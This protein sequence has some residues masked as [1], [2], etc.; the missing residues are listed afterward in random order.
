MI[1][2]SEIR[3][4]DAQVPPTARSALINAN[5]KAF[6]VLSSNLYKDKPL[7]ILRELSANALDAHI[8]AGNT[9]TPFVVSLP[10]SLRPSL[11]IRDY[12]TG[13]DDQAILELYMTYFGSNKGSSNIFTGGLG[14][15]SKTPFAYTDA[16]SVVSRYNG[17]KRTYS[18]Y[19][20]AD[21]T[22]KIVLLQEEHTDE[23]N[24]LEVSVPVR[25]T[26][27]SDFARRAPWALRYF[28][29]GS[30]KL[31]GATPEVIEYRIKTPLYGIRNIAVDSYA[32]HTR[33]VMG[34]IGYTLDWASLPGDVADRYSTLQSLRGLDIFAPIGAVDI[35]ASREAL[36]YDRHSVKRIAEFFAEVERTYIEE[37][38]QE[39]ERGATPFEKARK[40]IALIYPVLRN[41]ATR[42]ELSRLLQGYRNAVYIQELP[43]E[44]QIG[45]VADWR[46]KQLKSS[47]WRV[48]EMD[49]ARTE[50]P[51][52]VYLDGTN[53]RY[54]QFS[55]L[56]RE[57]LENKEMFFVS[58]AAARDALQ[59]IMGSHNWVN[60]S[61]LWVPPVVVR[62]PRA[63]KKAGQLR[64]PLLQ[65]TR[66]FNVMV[67]ANDWGHLPSENIDAL[68]CNTTAYITL[69]NHHPV[70]LK[71]M[72]LE[73]MRIMESLGLLP[74]NF[75]VVGVPRAEAHAEGYLANRFPDL[76]TYVFRRI[77]EL[78]RDPQFRAAYWAAY[79]HGHQ[80][81]E[82]QREFMD[83][84]HELLSE[85]AGAPGHPIATALWDS[86]Q[87]LVTRAKYPGLERVEFSR[88]EALLQ[89]FPQTFAH[90]AAPPV[91]EVA[92]F[93]LFQL[94][95][96]TYRVF[97]DFYEP[98]RRRRDGYNS[99]Y[100][101]RLNFERSYSEMKHYFDLIKEASHD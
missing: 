57:W 86:Y 24:G 12:G 37:A 1:I 8:A 4:V 48:F 19:K 79:T 99:W 32:D 83:E 96:G 42:S 30:Y 58:G 31:I 81:E 23:H 82:V 27:F 92:F 7:A 22:P 18:A 55:E 40:A 21:G 89:C 36:S 87:H 62:K 33:V 52:F 45:R 10:S 25:K 67:S 93:P 3:A 9:Q 69:H 68:D 2:A 60:F 50:A 5:A 97:Q 47:W 80:L 94:F 66:G 29:A 71:G 59:A 74:D 56:N 85:L 84:N 101:F 95:M 15:G 51:L 49:M 38:K 64:T 46:H 70:G 91:S 53:D 39:I 44:G 100:R 41:H 13:L 6:Q 78:W 76:Q 11:V 65:K 72:T 61:D 75:T 26:D 63:P 90:I 98:R 88:L 20:D 73:A 77:H 17:F 14:L 35:Q 54:L 43:D 34:P 16:F 28:P